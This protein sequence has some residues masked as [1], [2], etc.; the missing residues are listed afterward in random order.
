MKRYVITEELLEKNQKLKEAQALTKQGLLCPHDDYFWWF[1]ENRLSVLDRIVKE[2]GTA[3]NLR[4]TKI[5]KTLYSYLSCYRESIEEAL[6]DLGYD[7]QIVRKRKSKSFYYNFD[8]LEKA[9]RSFIKVNNRFPTKIEIIK[10][11]KIDQR[12]IDLHG[13]INEIRKKLGYFEDI[14]YVDNSWYVNR[15]LPEF[16]I[17]QFLLH[18][19]IWYERDKVIHHDCNYRSDFYFHDGTHLELW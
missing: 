4:S 14:D 16:M 15:S 1:R 8:N 13:G 9:L 19:G 6:E 7:L 11:L 10:E 5:G 18:A 17:A 12:Y 3:D 2:H